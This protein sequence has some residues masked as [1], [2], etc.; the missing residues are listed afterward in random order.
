MLDAQARLSVLPAVQRRIVVASIAREDAQPPSSVF[1]LPNR[2]KLER[3]QNV[4]DYQRGG[5]GD[6]RGDQQ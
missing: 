2:Y 5:F 3:F 1:F 4:V 6:Q